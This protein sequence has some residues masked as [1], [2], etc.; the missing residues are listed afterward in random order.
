[1]KILF[2]A[3]CLSSFVFADDKVYTIKEYEKTPKTL[4]QVTRLA[5]KYQRS[6][7]VENVQ[8]LLFSGRPSR[9]L[10]SA[11]HEKAR[12]LIVDTINKSSPKNLAKIETF[13]IDTEAVKKSYRDDLDKYLASGISASSEEAVTMRLFTESMLGVL[14][15]AKGIE[16][17]NIVWEKKGFLQPEEVLIIGAHYDTISQDPKKLIVSSNG[18]MP[19]ADNNASGVAAALAVIEV[20][21]KVNIAKTIRVVFFDGEELGQSG[22]KAYVEAHKDEFSNLKIAGFINLLMLGHDT[23]HKDRLSKSGNMKAYTRTTAE[24]EKGSVLDQRLASLFSKTA[25]KIRSSVSFDPSQRADLFSSQAAFQEA[26]LG[27]IVLTHDW[28]NDFN[29]DHHTAQDFAETLNFATFHNA[30]QAIIGA[31]LAWS[32]DMR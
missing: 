6:M 29:T 3:L 31:A 5:I 25:K 27:A 13:K 17:H 9:F 20:A 28:E 14:D 26:G 22:S 21:S 4:S 18:S 10:G 12:A 8:N 32:F 1:M 23:T 11:G 19:G 15:Q 7:L 16:G 2:L 30:T 24:S